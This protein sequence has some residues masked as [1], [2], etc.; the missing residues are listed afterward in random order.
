M[1]AIVVGAGAGGAAAAWALARSGAEVLVLEAGGP[2]RPFTR[3]A[4]WA[5]PLRRTGLVG[6]RTIGAL[7]PGMRVT[8]AESD[9]LVIRGVAAGGSTVL[10]CGNWVRAERGLAEIG[11]DL[12][13]EFEELE[14]LLQPVP[15]PRERWRPTTERMFSAA[16]EMGLHPART[17]KVVDPAL[18]RACGL[19]EL[20]C[21][22]GARWDARRLLSEAR[23]LGAEVCLRAPV[24][25][26]VVEGG[27]ARGVLVAGS[28]EPIR[29]DAVLLAAGAIGTAEILRASG[30]PVADRLWVDIVLTLGGRLPRTRQLDEPPMVW[31]AARDGYILS[32]Y[33]DL[34]S[35]LV[36]RPWRGVPLR[37][38]VGVMVKLAEE[39]TGTVH[40]DGRV[41]KKVTSVDRALLDE[42][43][44]LAREIM[45]RAGVRGPFVEGVLN[46]GHLGGTVPL[47]RED[48]ASMHPA[49]LPDGL[50]VADLSLVPVSQGLPTMATTAAI[51]LRVARRVASL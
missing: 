20:G 1:K 22:S 11:L 21:A 14:I 10:S 51:A 36:H 16:E 3:L 45:E 23:R 47:R 19:C 30:L 17:P 26:V 13:A 50:W 6:P 25:R 37:D 18:C 43:I 12:S 49:A 28:R 41:E 44:A 35:H 8:R 48:V 32:P 31:Y 15:F 4:P 46:G 29:A 34:L 39:A 5:D 9:L 27:R 2:F 7:L 24:E 38:R 33:L 40:A 42:G